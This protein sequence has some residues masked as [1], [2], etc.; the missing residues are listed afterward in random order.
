MCDQQDLNRPL[1]L[2]FSV[3]AKKI[4][5]T[6]PILSELNQEFDHAVWM[7]KHTDLDAGRLGLSKEPFSCDVVHI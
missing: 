4:Y 7:G 3:V 6:G 2:Q 1:H 5:R